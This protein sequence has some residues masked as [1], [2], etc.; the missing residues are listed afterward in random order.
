MSPP[1]CWSFESVIIGPQMLIP[2]CFCSVPPSRPTST[3][4]LTERQSV[5]SEDAV[6]SLAQEDDA[7]AFADAAE[8][9]NSDV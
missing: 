3:R 9:E 5:T 1:L 2:T 8:F 6:L 7:A 4:S